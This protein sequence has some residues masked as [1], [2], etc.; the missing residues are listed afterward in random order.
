MDNRFVKMLFGDK[1]IANLLPATLFAL[2]APG[3]LLTVGGPYRLVSV[4]PGTANLQVV[5]VHALV[6][7]LI[8]NQLK[9]QFPA[10]Y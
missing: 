3:V 5:L 4:M 6:Y 1:P 8:L 2:L 7:A 10:Y 9:R